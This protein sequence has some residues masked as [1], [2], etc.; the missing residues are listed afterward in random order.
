MIKMNSI[1]A[2]I[3]AT[4]KCTSNQQLY[5]VLNKLSTIV[6]ENKRKN[7]F[8]RLIKY[9]FIDFLDEDMCKDLLK[10]FE[11]GDDISMKYAWDY[12]REDIAK[13]K[14]EAIRKGRKQGIKEGRK[15]GIK[16]GK[17]ESFRTF[18]IKMLKN[19]ESID[20]IKLY[21]GSSIKE[22][23]EIQNELNISS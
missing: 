16:E 17:S 8:K 13:E 21:S 18:I 15:E 9:I 22:I 3:L 2:Y 12:V 20:K 5:N 10:K 11:E 7:N 4:D 23:K 6:H 14:Q 19:G 1:V